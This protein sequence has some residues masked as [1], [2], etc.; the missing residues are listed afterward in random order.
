MEQAY[1]LWHFF[2]AASP[3]CLL[4]SGLQNSDKI[5]HKNVFPMEQAYKMQHFCMAA[6]PLCLLHSVLWKGAKITYEHAFSMEQACK[7]Q[8]FLHGSIAIVS[9]ALRTLKW[10]QNHTRARVSISK[11]ASIEN[12]AFFLYDWLAAIQT[13]M[14]WHSVPRMSCRLRHTVPG[15]LLVSAGILS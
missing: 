11:K 9:T 15:Q 6:L 7:M 13:V 1:K 3:L 5:M 8:C 2:M 12:T 10:C 4:C 14:W